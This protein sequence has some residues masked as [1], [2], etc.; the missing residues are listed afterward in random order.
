MKLAIM[1]RVVRV[2]KDY[3]TIEI[4]RHEFRTRALDPDVSA[5]PARS[6]PGTIK[7]PRD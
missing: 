6:I 7:A 5:I 4:L 2:E 1:G 3:A